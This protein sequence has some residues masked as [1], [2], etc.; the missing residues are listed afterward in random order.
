MGI[1]FNLNIFETNLINLSIVVSVVIFV[2]GDAFKVSLQERK[3][4]IVTAL[5]EANERYEQ[6]QAQLNEALSRLEAAKSKAQSIQQEA[7]AN[8]LQQKE[9][10]QS[11]F[12]LEED[13]VNKQFENDIYLARARMTK[14]LYTHMVHA[15]ISKARSSLVTHFSQVGHTKSFSV[16]VDLI[17]SEKEVALA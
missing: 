11:Q 17:D 10:I 7:P 6:A 9:S 12:A 13:R 14:T 2:I 3:Q 15:S 1:Q 16:M 4:G 5:N 8:A